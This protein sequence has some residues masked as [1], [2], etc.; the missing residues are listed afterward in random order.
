M[1]GAPQ[2]V[3]ISSGSQE[4]I[5]PAGVSGRDG[6]AGKGDDGL[7]GGDRGEAA[8]RRGGR[9]RR[10][11]ALLETLSVMMMMAESEQ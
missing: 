9:G 7:R 3:H 6:D 8:A 4:A 2:V 5:S 11:R 1:T 10:P